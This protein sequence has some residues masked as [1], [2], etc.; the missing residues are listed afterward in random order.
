MRHSDIR[1][2]MNTYSHSFRE[3]E[4]DAIERLPDLSRRL[5]ISAK[6]GSSEEG[7]SFA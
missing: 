1:L 4:A 3:D 6:T 2:T 7:K 5:N